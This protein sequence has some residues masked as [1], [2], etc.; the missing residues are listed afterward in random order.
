MPYELHFTCTASAHLVTGK[1]LKKL[2]DADPRALYA[3]S[4]KKNSRG[5]P[6]QTHLRFELYQ[7]KQILEAMR[8]N[9]KSNYA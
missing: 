7:E 1:R 9:L 6:T 8:L 3:A 2:P 4:H 5:C